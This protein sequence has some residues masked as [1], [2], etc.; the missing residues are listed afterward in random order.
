[1]ETCFLIRPCVRVKGL[2]VSAEEANDADAQFTLAQLLMVGGEYAHAVQPND[3]ES[4]A[5]FRRAADGGQPC[6]Q[7]FAALQLLQGVLLIVDDPDY[8]GGFCGLVP[9]PHT[10]P[11]S[12]ST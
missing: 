7:A 12:G 6:A 2:R 1:M 3:A 9:G 8:T 5:M 10:R 11:L 4:R